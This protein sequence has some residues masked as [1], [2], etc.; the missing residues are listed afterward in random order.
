MDQE[1]LP[2]ETA[3]VDEAAV[4]EDQYDDSDCKKIAEFEKLVQIPSWCSETFDWMD[5]DARYVADECQYANKGDV[6]A[7]STNYILRNQYVLISQIYARDPTARI[8]P[9]PMMGPQPPGLQE[10]AK[11]L[12]LVAKRLT[13]EADF[14][15]KLGGAIQDVQTH[16]IAWLKV[17]TQS[18]ISKDPLGQARH[19]DQ[20]DNIA[21]L[22]VLINEFQNGDF[23]EDSSE[24]ADLRDL[25]DTVRMYLAGN[26]REDMARNPPQP[27]SSFDQFGMETLVPD[28][29]DPRI[30]QMAQLED[31]NTQMEPQ[32]LPEVPVFLGVNIDEVLPADIR[33]DWSITRPEDF[34]N[35][36]WVAH[37]VYMSLDDIAVRWHVEQTELD[38]S[39]EK[40]KATAGKRRTAES[41]NQ[42][43]RGSQLNSD[44]VMNDMLSVWELWDK[45]TCRRYVWIEGMDR[46]VVNEVAKNTWHR[47]FPFFP[48]VF[49]RVT[50]RFLPVSDVT[51][52]RP[53]QNEIN[54]KRTQFNEATGAAQPRYVVAAGAISEAEKEKLEQA[55]A[56]SVTE[57]QHPDTVDI[58]ELIPMKIDPM[59]YD[60][61]DAVRE[62]EIS[63]GIPQ[64]A[65]GGVGGAEFATE[66]AVANQQMGVQADRR[67]T[68]IEELIRDIN[69]CVIEMALQLF[70]EENIKA[71]VGPGAVWPL[72]ERDHLWRQLHVVIIPGASGKP[73]AEKVLAK[74]VGF[75]DM[76]NRLGLVVNGLEVGRKIVDELDLGID[77]DR[78]VM[79][80]APMPVGPGGPGGPK[81]AGSGPGAGAP[82]MS[83]RSGGPPTPETVNNAPSGKVQ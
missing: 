30:A 41:E 4:A 25:S 62:I 39:V 77:F 74:W 52:Q 60:K 71:M 23:N 6:D 1:P 70:P 80:P 68:V 12:E 58:K 82:P 45:A 29:N 75:S 3:V 56:Y 73:D 69:E 43:N 50:G 19:D 7:V 46:F 67:R 16:G 13:N 76:M 44:R 36:A 5:S 54:R 48:L 8:Q 24:Y 21:R 26:L 65:A 22:Q 9:A 18:D 61:S 83:E 40:S 2:E 81:P 72:I 55:L 37:R 57:L 78:Y 10:F 28:P 49:N 47:F 15:R 42:A 31:P 34:Y 27:V 20:L 53:L 11:T 33:F 64:Q 17:T 51:L 38:A 14:R 32:M 59:L 66:V 79:M 63:A 35:A